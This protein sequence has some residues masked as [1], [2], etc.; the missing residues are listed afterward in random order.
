[1]DLRIA[2]LAG[3]GIGPEITAEARRTLDRTAERFGHRFEYREAPVGAAAIDL[4]GDPYPEE[5][6]RICL[7]SDAVLFGAIATRNT[8]T[9]RPPRYAPNRVCCACAAH[10]GSTPTCGP[11][12]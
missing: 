2:L 5:T 11:S 1:M 4:T 3:D 12:P 7:E 8:T 9:T 10:W 6:H